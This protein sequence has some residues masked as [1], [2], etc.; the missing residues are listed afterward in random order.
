MPRCIKIFTFTACF[1]YLHSSTKSDSDCESDADTE[2][3]L[4]PPRERVALFQRLKPTLHDHP[5]LGRY[6]YGATVDS[7]SLDDQASLIEQGQPL[8]RKMVAWLMKN[9]YTRIRMKVCAIRS[10]TVFSLVWE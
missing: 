8:V 3:D 6:L 5:S 9:D 4:E 7:F 2:P 1:R 10:Q